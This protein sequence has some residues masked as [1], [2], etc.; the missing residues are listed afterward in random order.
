MTHG[1]AGRREKHPRILAPLYTVGIE[2]AGR[3]KGGGGGGGGSR[4]GN[5]TR[6]HGEVNL[7]PGRS[8]TPPG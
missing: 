7:A 5:A 1:T 4:S 2:V 6:G 3:E 8:S